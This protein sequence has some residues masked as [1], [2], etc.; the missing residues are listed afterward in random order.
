ML[1]YRR[2]SWDGLLNEKMGRG[3]QITVFPVRRLP[4]A[5]F[6]ECDESERIEEI[7]LEIFCPFTYKRYVSRSCSTDDTVLIVVMRTS[8]R[9]D[10]M[11]TSITCDL[12]LIFSI[13]L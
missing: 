2:E 9:I 10:F 3:K 11:T 1:W 6:S 12:S 13:C 4:C 8:I 5:P 7:S